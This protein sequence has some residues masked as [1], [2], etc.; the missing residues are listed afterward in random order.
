MQCALSTTGWMV[1]PLLPGYDPG[2][3]RL[4]WGLEQEGAVA[5]HQILSLPRGRREVIRR[6]LGQPLPVAREA[7]CKAARRLGLSWQCLKLH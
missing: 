1:R 3:Q 4:P 2:P 5:G 6:G 7:V